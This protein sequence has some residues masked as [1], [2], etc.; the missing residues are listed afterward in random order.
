MTVLPGTS[1]LA[2]LP[3]VHRDGE[4]WASTLWDLRTILGQ[5]VFERVLVAALKL[6]PRRPSM[7]DA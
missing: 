6:T 2:G 5:S 1:T 3:A 7:L 4:I